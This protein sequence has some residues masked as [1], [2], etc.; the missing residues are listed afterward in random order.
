[1]VEAGQAD[2]EAEAELGEQLVV[3][4]VELLGNVKAEERGEEAGYVFL[5]GQEKV[6]LFPGPA[7]VRAVHLRRQRDLRDYTDTNKKYNYGI[8]L[9]SLLLYMVA[10][11]M[12]SLT[13]SWTF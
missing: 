6:K 3:E 10:K 1:M 12:N 11:F 2:V 7:D 13:L 5:L 4:G 8:S 9:W